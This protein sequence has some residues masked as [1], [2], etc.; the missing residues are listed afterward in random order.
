MSLPVEVGNGNH[1]IA[2]YDYE[3]ACEDELS[4]HCGQVVTIISKNIAESGDEGWWIGQIENQIGV[5]PCNYVTQVTPDVMQNIQSQ[6]FFMG[7]NKDLSLLNTSDVSDDIGKNASL[8]FLAKLHEINY[9]ELEIKDFLGAGGFGKV[10]R[11]FFH[12]QEVA[13]KLAKVNFDDDIDETLKN[14]LSEARLFSL[15]NHKNIIGLIGVCLKKPNLCLVLEYAEGGPLNR[16][17]AGRQLPPPVL[18]DWAQQ[19]A[20]GMN[21]LHTKASK[22]LIH[23]DLKSSNGRYLKEE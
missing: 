12:H 9:E 8:N 2:M 7:F 13:I 19:I 16:C 3:A 14:V 21:Y 17:L 6:S 18:V 23:R 20:E 22:P 10:F 11:G 15:L 4:L 1:W 5:F